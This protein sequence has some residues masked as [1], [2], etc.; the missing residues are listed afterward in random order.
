MLKITKTLKHKNKHHTFYIF[1]AREK[2][3]ITVNK[4]NILPTKIA[5]NFSSSFCFNK[6]S[7]ILIPYNVTNLYPKN[8]IALPVTSNALVTAKNDSYFPNFLIIYFPYLSLA[9]QDKFQTYTTLINSQI[10]YH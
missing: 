8:S 2:Q 3:V 4:I 5:E 1:R 10:L 7:C 9:P 6:K